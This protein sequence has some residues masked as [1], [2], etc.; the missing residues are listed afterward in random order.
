MEPGDLHV[1]ELEVGDWPGGTI[2]F[3]DCAYPDAPDGGI[4]I[5]LPLVCDTHARTVWWCLNAQLLWCDGGPEEYAHHPMVV[6]PM[7]DLPY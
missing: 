5:A 6:A 1:G 2:T 3:M 4:D 7:E